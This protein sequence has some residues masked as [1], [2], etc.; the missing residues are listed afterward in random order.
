MSVRRQRQA[1]QQV[2]LWRPALPGR[3][4]T[5]L[6]YAGIVFLIG[7]DTLQAGSESWLTL[8]TLALI[9]GFGVYLLALRPSLRYDDSGIIVRNPLHTIQIS[10]RDV[11]DV[12]T[13]SYGGIRIYRKG[14]CSVLV[15][16]VQ[17]SNLNQWLN[18]STRADRVANDLRTH[19]LQE[20]NRKR[21]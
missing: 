18:R 19:V 2:T 4:V 16:A 5:I 14:H 8:S 13:E 6:A 11:E 20:S 12:S 21:S 17:K 1:S 10:W 15:W 7:F 3:I 9:V